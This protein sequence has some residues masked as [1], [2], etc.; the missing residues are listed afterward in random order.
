MLALDADF[1]VYLAFTVYQPHFKNIE[2]VINISERVDVK[3]E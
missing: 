3:I 1:Y 2:K